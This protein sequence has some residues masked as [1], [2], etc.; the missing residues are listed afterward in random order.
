VTFKSPE[1]QDKRKWRGK[2][3][4]RAEMARRRGEEKDE[5]IV[6]STRN[7]YPKLRDG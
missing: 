1:S 6:A 3:D 4:E 7:S 2:R 5:K